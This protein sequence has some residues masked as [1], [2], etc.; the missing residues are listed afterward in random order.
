MATSVIC[1]VL[2]VIA[3]CAVRSYK[4]RLT[5]GCCG[6]SSEDSVKKVRVKDRDPAHYPYEKFLYI[7]GMS[8][9]NCTSRVENALNSL[10]GV[11]AAVDLGKEEAR[12]RMKELLPEE[13]LK[14]TVKKAG[15]LV[16]KIK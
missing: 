3:V 5:S 15:Y 1:L 8:C 11:W 14:E 6:A 7:D 4:K 12:V 9:A 2:V 16:Y 10:D 13:L